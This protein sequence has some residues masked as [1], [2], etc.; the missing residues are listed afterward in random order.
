VTH[1][2][3]PYYRPRLSRPLQALL[4]CACLLTGSALHAENGQD[5][6]T[7]VA[8]TEG[9]VHAIA[10][11]SDGTTAYL[12][13]AM[14]Y[15]GYRAPNLAALDA[16]TGIP[17]AGFPWAD[18]TV[19]AVV[20]DGA[21]GWWV[22][23]NFSHLGSSTAP[24][25]GVNDV[26]HILANNSVVTVPLAFN[27]SIIC[28]A[29]Y[30]GF[31]YVGGN[32]TGVSS[33]VRDYA[34]AINVSSNFGQLTSWNP[35]ANG[36]V[37]SIA[38]A[39][40]TGSEHI[41]L[42]GNFTSISGV[43]R[44]YL[45]E[46]TT[47]TGLPLVENM[48]L[49]TAP[50]GSVATSGTNLFYCSNSD[51]FSTGFDKRGLAS[52]TST[53][54]VP[55]DTFPEVSGANS[56]VNACITDGGTGWYV[57]GSFTSI[58]GSS[59]C[60]YL[61]HVL[62]D[63][64]IDP[65]FAPQPNSQV[66]ALLLV[67][68]TLYFGGTFTT[69][70]TFA[71]SY[72]AAVTAA[73][74]TLTSWDPEANQPVFTLLSAA[75]SI[76]VGGDFSKIG[77][78]FRPYLARL[79]P[80]T[81]LATTGADLWNLGP[82]NDVHALATIGN[83]LYVGGYHANS[84]SS[85]NVPFLTSLTSG[86]A[87]NPAFPST[88]GAVNAM[89][90]DGAGGWYVGGN[91]TQIGSQS[92]AYLAHVLSTFA[93][94]TSFQSS[95][96]GQIFS[97]ATS[98]DGH[99]LYAGGSFSAIGG[100]PRN[101]LAAL[102]LV[103]GG[104]YGQATTWAPNPN[105]NV[106]AVAVA[107]DNS[108]FAGGYF[109]QIGGLTRN[110]LAQLDPA[111]AAANAAFNPAANSYV[112][113][114]QV[115]GSRIFVG[116]GFNT[117]SGDGTTPYLCSFTTATG[118]RDNWLAGCS[119]TVDCLLPDGAADLR[120]GGSFGQLGG[121]N[122]S[123]VGELST[124][125][126]TAVATSW[127]PSA[128]NTV[129]CLG[130]ISGGV[131]VGGSFTAIGGAS[132]SCFA[133]LDASAGL[134]LPATPTPAL[135]NTVSCIMASGSVVA[136]GGAFKY[137]QPVSYNGVAAYDIPSQTALATFTDG[138]IDGN[139]VNTMTVSNG[140][141]Y[142]GG[143]FS[144]IGGALRTGLG[145]LNPT[146]GAATTF[147]PILNGQVQSLGSFGN[148]L[149][150]GGTY[151]NSFSTFNGTTRT[152][153]GAVDETSFAATAFNPGLDSA[154]YAITP[155][156][157]GATVVV[158]GAFSFA[159]YQGKSSL[160][161]VDSTTGLITSWAPACNGSAYEIAV[162]GSTLFVSGNFS[163]IGGQGRS[164]MG[165]VS[166][167]TGLATA[168]APSPNASAS[169]L[170]VLPGVGVYAAGSFTVVKSLSRNG[171]V[172]MNE[173][174]GTPSAWNPG[175]RYGS[176]IDSIVPTASAVIVGGS[177]DW[178]G[179][180]GVS[181]LAAISV[182]TGAP[183][184]WAPN[185][186]GSV[187][188]ALAVSGTTVYLGGTFS[189]VNGQTRTNLAAVDASTG[190]VGTWND[191]TTGPVEALAIIG[192]DLYVGGSFTGI[193]GT[194]TPNLA[195]VDLVSGVNTAFAPHPD[196]QVDA[197][198]VSGTLLYAGGGFA[199]LGASAQSDLAAFDTTTGLA[200]SWAPNA[201]GLV[202]TLFIN[203]GTIYAGGDFTTITTQGQQY[204]AAINGT[205]S[206]IATWQPSVN[207]SV[208]ALS[209]GNADLLIGGTF[210]AVDGLSIN[211]NFDSINPSTATAFGSWP[212][213]SNSVYALLRVPSTNKVLIGGNFGT[214]TS[215]LTGALIYD[216]GVALVPLTAQPNPGDLNGDGVVDQNDVNL[217]LSHFGFRITD[218]G[219]LP[220]ADANGDG[221]VNV[222]DLNIVLSHLGDHYP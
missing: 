39:G 116:G 168:W 140:N 36:V 54:S 37:T 182:A 70:D 222:N 133:E 180:F 72:V 16:T 18:N 200:T 178:Y 105:S 194:S 107:A 100:A 136:L 147:N 84:V 156:T 170:G 38:E 212:T 47:D 90:S 109:T 25:V 66:N 138:T 60:P 216:G 49:A 186:N 68:T 87:V 41:F 163:S 120:V 88:N 221:V 44:N 189:Q 125:T 5:P 160:F 151:Y 31:L 219:W 83:T 57:G 52:F 183:V 27:S 98:S 30:N 143:D 101:N 76:W 11:S 22:A 201:N 48:Q 1:P 79:D 9:A 211:P 92:I 61:A 167:S 15:I 106:Y 82:N 78:A 119:Y 122:R 207:S 24:E 112:F 196:G 114:L 174:D 42:G 89:L 148:T 202:R 81:G 135:D 187:V 213:P 80:T 153:A 99:T 191:N 217:V 206:L 152:F 26:A 95:A 20:S 193:N 85:Y 23:G 137:S 184:A 6:Q 159:G 14:D 144:Q 69:V 128:N 77:T 149:Y 215:K 204:V 91:F 102:S 195:S 127:N 192:A 166:T 28:M 139:N 4:W 142:V 218:S 63:G 96:N 17:A 132:R 181:G 93:I 129:S 113:A 110:Y 62:V 3:A 75:G 94:D 40:T 117:I 59:A 161:E 154:V 179:G 188:S 130:A 21:G 210:G 134:V 220:A 67:G 197:L 2:S 73:N 123:Y 141:L 12:G 74:G 86:G 45:A 118:V 214:F 19:S 7:P 108:I 209:F 43:H 13:G 146:T 164:Y 157:D 64:S 198:A 58:G 162:D 111:S 35:S 172:A 121:Q 8:S 173:T 203:G 97:L 50:N 104:T 34:A 46:V 124:A 115:I 199:H 131:A 176:S 33:Y 208:Y 185:V 169:A 175:C 32:F 155:S 65:A 190:I 10:L 177:Q 51:G 56:T 55:L 165:A 126:G 145:C 53:G 205:G 150:L 103:S 158:G 29:L 71:R 171:L